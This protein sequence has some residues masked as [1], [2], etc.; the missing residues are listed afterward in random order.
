MK[1]VLFFLIAV[2]MLLPLASCAKT[3][4]PA[5]QQTQESTQPEESTQESDTSEPET[6]PEP[7]PDGVDHVNIL[8]MGSAEGD[9]STNNSY[10]LTHILVTVDPEQRALKFTTFLI[11]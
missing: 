5:A 2:F 11:I 6:T 3:E 1:R 4:E 9:F 10:V 8:L 7:I